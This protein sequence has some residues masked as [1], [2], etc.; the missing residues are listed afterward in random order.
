M[1]KNSVPPT[2]GSCK[3]IPDT[4]TEVARRH[5]AAFAAIAREY[6]KTEAEMLAS[7][8]LCGF[9]TSAFIRAEQLGIPLSD[10]VKP[11]SFVRRILFQGE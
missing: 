7:P 9:A 10:T 6:N 3:H 1:S 11:D 5:H 8:Q 2:N 4:F